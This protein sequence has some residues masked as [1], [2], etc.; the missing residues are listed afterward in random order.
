VS[1]PEVSIPEVSIPE[2]PIPEVPI[3]EVPIPEVPT[4][5]VWY[6]VGLPHQ[7]G[8]AGASFSRSWW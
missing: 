4:T 7:E 8:A 2:V 1:I 6:A 3:P 5:A